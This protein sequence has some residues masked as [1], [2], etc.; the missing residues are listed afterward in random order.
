MVDQPALEGDQ[1]GGIGRT[2]LQAAYDPNHERLGV[3]GHVLEDPYQ[4]AQAL[5]RFGHVDISRRSRHVERLAQRLLTAFHILQRHG[6]QLGAL[7]QIPANASRPA[8]TASRQ[9]IDAARAI[10]VGQLRSCEMS[11]CDSR[12]SHSVL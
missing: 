1:L 6:L 2:K 9:P 12:L 4:V 3:V 5:V 8:S 10:D 7:T 11:G